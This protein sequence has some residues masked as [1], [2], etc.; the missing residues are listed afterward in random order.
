MGRSYKNMSPRQKMMKASSH[1]ARG[2]KGGKSVKNDVS[3]RVR[4]IS[5]SASSDL[6]SD[7]PINYSQL[8][9]RGPMQVVNQVVGTLIANGE[10]GLVIPDP[11]F[12]ETNFG[13]VRID[14]NKLN[15]APFGMT[16]VCEILNPSNQNRDFRGQIIE[17]LGDMGNND[18]RMLSVLRQ[19]GL[20]Q[21]FPEAVMSEVEPLPV[22]PDPEI[23]ERE[24]A[25]GRTDHRA[26]LTITIDGE[27]AKDLDDAI[28]LE[29]LSDGNFKLY[30]HIA[31]VSHYVRA[32]TALDDE[33]LLRGTSVYLVDRVIPMLPPK[34]S[35]G[36]CSLNPAV[37][38]LTLTAEMYIDREGRTYDGSIY[39][40]VIRSDHRM[41]YNEC[42]RILTDPRPSDADEYGEVVPMLTSM[43][44]LATILKRMRDGK[45]AI[46][47]DFPET[48]VILD[49]EGTPTDVMPYPINFCHGIIEQFMIAANEFVAETFCTMNY[50]FVYRVHEDPD[51]IKI[52]RFCN[53]ARNFGAVGRLSGKITPMDIVRFMDTVRDEDVKPMLDTVLLR[54][55]AKA[56]YSSDCLGHFGLASKYYCHFTSPIRRYPDL[57]I[58]RIIKSYIHEE[59][60]RRYFAG[61]VEDVAAHSSDMERNAVDAERASVDIKVAEYM[62]DKVGE[63]YT[64]VI[65]SII[66]AGVFVMLPDT[67]EGFVPFKS[68][69]DHYIFDER[70]YRAIG[71]RSGNKLTI[72]MEVK[73]VVAAV[74]TDLVHIDFVFEE[75]F[76]NYERKK[77]G[78]KKKR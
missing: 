42:Y 34:L 40:S 75:G 68:M 51:I 25:A 36:L 28:S 17:V 44:E 37:D 29:P 11:A 35:N 5:P 4:T 43:R 45:G 50:P 39:E 18:V 13:N 24:I 19:F 27:E 16:V 32:E 21:K 15:G 10:G 48:R 64:G 30:V 66:G 38:R 59:G 20:S 62:K 14:K 55:M 31:D 41:S 6:L 72:G 54:S 3:S 46:N 1:G 71:S 9:P 47:F 58:H 78:G 73:V 57:Y 77:G 33:A 61:R 63:H 26:L 7:T 8:A 74:D 49:Q 65:T 23:V 60:K 67:V 2:G 69:R 52:A 70:A 12:K 53:V 76:E 56:R 22:N